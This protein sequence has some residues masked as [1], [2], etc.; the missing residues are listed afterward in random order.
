MEKQSKGCAVITGASRGIGAAIAERL[1]ADGFDIVVNYKSNADKAEAVAERCR[2]AGVRA[3]TVQ[4]DV[5]VLAECERL[6]KSA[7]AEFGRIDVLVNN[8]GITR[9]ALLMRMTEA[10]F[11]EVIDANLKSAFNM[12]KSVSSHMLKARAGR[13][14]NITSV[15]GISGVAGQANYSSSKAGMIGLTMAASKELGSRGVTVNA[16]APGFIDTEMTDVLSDSVKSAAL[17]NIS[18]KRF[19]KPEEVA[20][21]VAFLASPSAS[22]IT[23]HVL[24]MDGGLAL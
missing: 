6:V 11:D 24:V 10:Q 13:I 20:G 23:G 19:G 4:A 12:T 3:V 22:Y 21:T 14:I 18:L 2:A 16:V 17:E 15:S 8:A 9:D 7:M 5:S 1:A